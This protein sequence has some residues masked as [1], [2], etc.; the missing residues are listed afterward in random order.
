MLQAVYEYSAIDNNNNFLVLENI[1][2]TTAMRIFVYI[3]VCF[4]EIKVCVYRKSSCLELHLFRFV[5][6]LY[7]MLYNKL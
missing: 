6:L 4:S 2:D 1:T 3:F 7:N 5:D